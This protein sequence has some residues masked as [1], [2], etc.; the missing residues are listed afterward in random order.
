MASQVRPTARPLP[1]RVCTNSGLA[2]APAAARAVADV[3]AARL[4]GVEVGAG[5]DFA[6]EILAGQPDFEVVSFG[7]GEAGVAGA[8]ENAAIR[9]VEGFENLFGVAGEALVLGV[10]FF[11]ASELDQLDFLKLVLADDAAR[12]FAG[13]A[14]FGAEAWRVGGEARW[15]SAR[16]RGFRRDRD[17]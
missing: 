11:R 8:E 4:E 7:G 10:G 6:V 16:R 5:R 12:V 14:G 3:G 15:A 13:C 9:Q 2:L 1:L 17:W